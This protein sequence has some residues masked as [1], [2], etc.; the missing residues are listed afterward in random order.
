VDHSHLIK[1]LQRTLSP[2]DAEALTAIR[3]ANQYL[4]ACDESWETVF[5]LSPEVDQRVSSERVSDPRQEV[6]EMVHRTLNLGE[7]FLREI[8]RANR[9]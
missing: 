9:K 5:R 4:K 3:K 1:L 8:R 6:F 7:G 2:S